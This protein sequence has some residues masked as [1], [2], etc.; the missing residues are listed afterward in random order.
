MLPSVRELNGIIFN[1]LSIFILPAIARSDRLCFPVSFIAAT[2]VGE[3][4]SA[5]QIINRN[6]TQFIVMMLIET[7]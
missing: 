2:N 6:A 7:D 3:V 5:V 4:N 1:D